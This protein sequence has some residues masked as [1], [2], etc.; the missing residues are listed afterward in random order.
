M[1]VDFEHVR[2]GFW[3]L[4][5]DFGPLRV[6]LYSER[7]CWASG[8]RFCALGVDFGP[9]RV[10]YCG[11]LGVDFWT[12]GSRVLAPESLFGAF[13]SLLIVGF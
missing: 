11:H 7:Q 13:G 12:S 2:V 3:P 8:S 6:N 9:L 4:E 1:R 5:L 10:N